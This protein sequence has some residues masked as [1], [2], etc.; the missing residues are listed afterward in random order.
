ML[1][2]DPN[3]PAAIATDLKEVQAFWFYKQ[4]DVR[5]CCEI[6]FD[7]CPMQKPPMKW[8]GGNTS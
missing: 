7:G 2:N 8:R 3:F 5:Q 6:S 1:K 4:N